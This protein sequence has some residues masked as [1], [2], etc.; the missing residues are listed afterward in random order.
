MQVFLIVCVELIILICGLLYSAISS[1]DNAASNY[2]YRKGL[3]G[4]GR[5]LI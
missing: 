4:R 1:S 5:G 3:E 2:I